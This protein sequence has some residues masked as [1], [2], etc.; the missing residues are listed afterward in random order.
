MAWMRP[1]ARA[2]ASADSTHAVA[3]HQANALEGARPYEHIKVVHGAGQI[4]NLYLGV[5]EGLPD[6]GGHVFVA[7]QFELG[8][9]R[10]LRVRS[11]RFRA[12]RMVSGRAV[13][14][15]LSASVHPSREHDRRR[16]DEDG[17]DA[18]GLDPTGANAAPLQGAVARR[19]Y[20]RRF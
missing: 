13:A 18:A 2:S 8:N 17:G 10:A 12:S 15:R 19:G 4:L 1:S 20:R 3:V 6:E 7:D 11:I 5:G 16:S 14:A 9:S